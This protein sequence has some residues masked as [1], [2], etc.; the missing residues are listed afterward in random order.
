MKLELVG[1]MRA[2]HYIKVLIGVE[3]LVLYII[4]GS[5]LKVLGCP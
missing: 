1:I 5:L 2:A 3:N 4:E